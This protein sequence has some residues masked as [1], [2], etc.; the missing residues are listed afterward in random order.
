M[1]DLRS[2]LAAY[3]AC[4][5]ELREAIRSIFPLA[6]VTV[7]SAGGSLDMPDAVERELPPL[8]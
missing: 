2:R 4:V 1:S 5:N 7:T 8:E 3:G 6:H